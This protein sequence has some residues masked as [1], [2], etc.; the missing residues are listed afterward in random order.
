MRVLGHKALHPVFAEAGREPVRQIGDLP[1]GILVGVEAGF[2]GMR[3]L[4]DARF[5][6]DQVETE[7]GVQRIGQ[8][9]QP[10]VQ[11]PQH[12]IRIAQ[13]RAG[14]DGDA[15]HLAV[16]AEEHRFQKTQTLALTFQSFGQCDAQTVQAF[17]D[18]ILGRDRLSETMCGAEIG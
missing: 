2:G 5:Q 16:G 18:D 10:L 13:G 11:K 4:G 1:A 6:P 15:L 3:L 12:H 8:R 7:A 9:I 17:A 14:A